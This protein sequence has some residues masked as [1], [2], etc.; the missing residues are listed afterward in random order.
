[1][2]DLRTAKLPHARF[3]KVILSGADLRCVDLR[4]AELRGAKLRQVH[5]EGADLTGAHLEDAELEGAWIDAK[6][7]PEALRSAPGV[8]FSD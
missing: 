7:K 5:L 1:L 8:Q 2:T 4:E 3:D 6:T